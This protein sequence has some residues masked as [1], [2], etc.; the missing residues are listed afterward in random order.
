MIGVGEKLPDFRVVGVRPG[1]TQPEQDGQS[2]FEPLTAASFPG[3]WRLILFYPR[4]FADDTPE[5]LAAFGRLA[6]EFDAA[7]CTLIA[8][9]IDNE[10]VKLAWRRERRELGEAP[11]W[12]FADNSGKF[13]R[14]LGVLDEAEGVPMR[15]SFLIDPQGVIQHVYV[16]PAAAPRDPADTLRVLKL[17]RENPRPAAQPFPGAGVT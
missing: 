14:A 3:R 16:T 10:L 8:G 12:A 11:V 1:F 7:D 13:A 6:G 4:D 15:A 17:L 9:S 5:E 2:A